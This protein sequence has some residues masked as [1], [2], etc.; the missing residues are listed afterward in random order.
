[1]QGGTGKN[2]G[3]QIKEEMTNIQNQTE[4]QGLQ[5]DLDL[6]DKGQESDHS[7]TRV[8]LQ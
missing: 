6:Q 7:E 1:M 8:D 4:G 5:G 2:Q 3:H